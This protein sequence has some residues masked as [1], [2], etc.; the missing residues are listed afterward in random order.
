MDPLLRRLDILYLQMA[1]LS[2]NGGQGSGVGAIWV[3]DFE[4]RLRC[5]V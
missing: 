3:F 4:R 5:S 2:W 1:H